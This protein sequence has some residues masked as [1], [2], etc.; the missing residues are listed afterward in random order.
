M[1]TA[2]DVIKA[3][4]HAHNAQSG[5]DRLDFLA[6]F[7][8]RVWEVVGGG[9]LGLRRHYERL[10]PLNPQP[11][12]PVD[13]GRVLLLTVAR[14]I[15]IVGGRDESAQ[16]AFLEDI[17]DWCGTGWPRRWPFPSPNPEPGPREGLRK[18]LRQQTLL[19][20]AL[21]AAELAARYPTGELQDLFGKASEQLTEAAFG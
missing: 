1:P 15:I 14:G 2:S 4:A 3:L 16:H 20:G 18:D 7:D 13:T 19:G 6:S 11:L 9:P 5:F 10:S 8:D 17:E 12:P 21:A